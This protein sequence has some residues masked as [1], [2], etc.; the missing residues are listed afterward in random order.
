MMSL[1]FQRSIHL[2][3]EAIR[4]LGCPGIVMFLNDIDKNSSYV[5]IC[6]C[7]YFSPQLRFLKKT[8]Q[9]L[10]QFALQNEE[11]NIILTFN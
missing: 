8:L 11:G 4:G 9:N 7:T 6:I 3:L 1:A 2:L 10:H 5:C